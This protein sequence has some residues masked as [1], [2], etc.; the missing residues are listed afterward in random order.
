MDF[1]ENLQVFD[2]SQNICIGITIAKR[3]QNVT[4]DIKNHCK[5]VN[6]ADLE[7]CNIKLEN[8]KN[9]QIINERSIF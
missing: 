7:V 8:C 4:Y 6:V 5:N 9:P 2:F 3:L 1:S